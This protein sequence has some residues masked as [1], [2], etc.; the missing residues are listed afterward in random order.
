MQ[1]S[2][3]ERKEKMMRG[4][5]IMKWAAECGIGIHLSDITKLVEMLEA[6]CGIGIHSSDI[7]K[8]VEMLEAEGY[9]KEAAQAK[10]STAKKG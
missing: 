4:D 2:A 8:L 9:K 10:E 1:D 5:I 3:A 7:T 6:E